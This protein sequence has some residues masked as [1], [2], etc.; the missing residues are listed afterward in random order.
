MRIKAYVL[1]IKI[2][3][4]KLMSTNTYFP[5]DMQCVIWVC[6]CGYII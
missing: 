4:A 1:S 6:G 3:K 5:T 2:H